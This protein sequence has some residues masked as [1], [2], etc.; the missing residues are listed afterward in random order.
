MNSKKQQL[1]HVISSQRE[2]MHEFLAG[3]SLNH[4]CLRVNKKVERRGSQSGLNQEVKRE[5]SYQGTSPDEIT[6]VKF[7]N[8]CGYEFR[9]SSDHHAKLRIPHLVEQDD[10]LLNNQSSLIMHTNNGEQDVTQSVTQNQNS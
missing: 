1:R 6:L 5:K 10:L 2:L 9:S 4:G 8:E 7:A 3:M